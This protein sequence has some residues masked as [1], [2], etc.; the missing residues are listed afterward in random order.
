[1][2][3]RRIVQLSLALF[4]GLLSF[5]VTLYGVHAARAI[6]FHFNPAWSILYCLLP[7]FSLPVFLLGLVYRKLVGCQAVFAVIYLAVYSELNWR[8]CASLGYCGSLASTV[9]M[10]LRTHAVLAFFAAA[11]LSVAL[12]RLNR[13]QRAAE[14]GK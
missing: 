2:K 1:M 10:T 12:A 14:A 3:L 5:A 6:D 4:A 9:L 13:R 7:I 8:T 11:I